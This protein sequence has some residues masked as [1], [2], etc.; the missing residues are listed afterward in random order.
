MS[1]PNCNKEQ[2]FQKH[3]YKNEYK[4][5]ENSKYN[6]YLCYNKYS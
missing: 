5:L 2:K 3:E 6:F 4:N 1:W